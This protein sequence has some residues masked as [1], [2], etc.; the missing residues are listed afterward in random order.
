MTLAAK[1]GLRWQLPVCAEG[2]D[3]GDRVARLR[4]PVAP[5]ASAETL[6]RVPNHVTSA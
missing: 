3:G 1:P 4:L 6:L 2:Y 5:G